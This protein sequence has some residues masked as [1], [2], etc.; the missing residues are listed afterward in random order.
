MTTAVENTTIDEVENS[1]PDTSSLVATN[2][3][4]TKIEEVRT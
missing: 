3:L 2:I 1:I 4:N